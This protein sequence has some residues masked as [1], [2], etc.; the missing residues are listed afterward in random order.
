MTRKR[1]K[2]WRRRQYQLLK[3]NAAAPW[4]FDVQWH[5]MLACPPSTLIVLLRVHTSFYEKFC[6]PAFAVQYCRWRGIGPYPRAPH[7]SNNNNMKYN[8]KDNNNFGT[9]LRHYFQCFNGPSFC[10]IKPQ[11]WICTFEWLYEH[12]ALV[13]CMYEM[14]AAQRRAVWQVLRRHPHL[15]P[16]IMT[17]ALE[18]QQQMTSTDQTNFI[19]LLLERLLKGLGQPLPLAVWNLIFHQYPETR[20][21]IPCA[22]LLQDPALFTLVLHDFN[23]IFSMEF[24]STCSPAHYYQVL[25]HD[26]AARLQQHNSYVSLQLCVRPWLHLWVRPVPE[27]RLWFWSMILIVIVEPRR[28]MANKVFTGC[29][30]YYLQLVCL[31]AAPEIQHTLG[32]MSLVLYAFLLWLM[33]T[34][35]KNI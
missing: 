33:H 35:T 7:P 17:L 21:L 2:A 3:S 8:N 16:R 19:L 32:K 5:I 10:V 24:L 4:L 14:H 28:T 18:I 34:T 11:R 26:H 13:G 15:I 6:L 31:L 20:S 25:L 30:L 23:H 9:Q 29:L 1:T 22:M 27:W 12:G